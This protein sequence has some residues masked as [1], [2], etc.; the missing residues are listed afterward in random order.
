MRARVVRLSKQM[1]GHAFDLPRSAEGQAALTP[2]Q[3]PAS[4]PADAR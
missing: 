4:L 3:P 1:I 2:R